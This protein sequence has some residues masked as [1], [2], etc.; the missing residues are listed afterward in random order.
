[1]CVYYEIHVFVV[2]FVDA[3]VDVISVLCCSAL[4]MLVFCIRCCGCIQFILVLIC[5]L[6]IYREIARVNARQNCRVFCFNVLDCIVY[7]HWM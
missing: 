6:K 4:A 3:L 2:C 5:V 7:V 1:M